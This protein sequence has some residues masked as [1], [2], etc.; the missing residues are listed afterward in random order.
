MSKKT[1]AKSA[2]ANSL[3]IVTVWDHHLS[4]ANS[5]CVFPKFIISQMKKKTVLS[6]LYKT[7]PIE[8][9][10]NKQCINDKRLSDYIYSSATL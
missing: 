4:N 5:D 3:T 7:L 1:N 9:I 6:N 2:L 10:G 8:K